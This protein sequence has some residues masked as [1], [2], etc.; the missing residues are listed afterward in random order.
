MKFD[1]S[2]KFVLCYYGQVNLLLLISSVALK[3]VNTYIPIPEIYFAGDGTYNKVLDENID[4]FSSIFRLLTCSPKNSK[5]ILVKKFTIQ[6]KMDD[7]RFELRW[8]HHQSTVVA[9]VGS[10]FR[11]AALVD[12]TL[13]CEDQRTYQAHKLVL[14]A[15]SNYFQ[16]SS[17]CFVANLYSNKNLHSVKF[18]ST[19]I[20]IN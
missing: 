7:R 9:A 6:F 15:C 10:L 8:R 5:N 12:V 19:P 16:V 20:R 17:H 4:L 1:R 14:S 18:K 2:N 11:D 13:A 3:W